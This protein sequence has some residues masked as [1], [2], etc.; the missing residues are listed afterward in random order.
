M[1]D[2]DGWLADEEGNLQPDVA[3]EINPRA[4]DDGADRPDETPSDFDELKVLFERYGVLALVLLLLFLLVTG[5]LSVV[6]ECHRL[7]S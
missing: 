6:A 5:L 1:K 2:D 7:V 3:R 4:R